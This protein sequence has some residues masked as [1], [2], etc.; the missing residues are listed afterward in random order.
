M[1]IENEQKTVIDQ[2]V[3]A[4]DFIAATLHDQAAALSDVTIANLFDDGGLKQAKS[5]LRS[6][7]LL[8]GQIES[9]RKELKSIALE[10]G[11]AVDGRAKELFAI[12]AP[13]RESLEAKIKTV[14][15]EREAQRR[16][17]ELER[18]AELAAAG[19]EFTGG[20]YRV[21][22]KMIE[23]SQITKLSD[24]DFDHIVSQGEQERKRLIAELEALRVE[25]ERIEA[26]RAAMAAERAELEALRRANDE[27]KRVDEP[28]PEPAPQPADM[29][30][31]KPTAQSLDYERG[32]NACK[33]L[34]LAILAESETYKTRPQIIQGIT[35]LDAHN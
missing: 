15:D 22:V 28:E 30:A 6:L 7:K 27:A 29:F 3:K 26:E 8:E 10:Y 18:I 13:H 11:R 4:Y 20:Y 12:S 21:G 9:K 16:K 32:F 5:N 14:E 33:S 1:Q 31:P 17:L 2:A 34:V 35:A 25:Q 24:E 23:P 19:Y